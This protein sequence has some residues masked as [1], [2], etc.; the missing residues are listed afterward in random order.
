MT[1]CYSSEASGMGDQFYDDLMT[2][3]QVESVRNKTPHHFGTRKEQAAAARYMGRLAYAAITGVVKK[4]AEAM[5]YL[6]ALAGAMAHEGEPVRWVTPAG[7]PCVNRYHEA[8]QKKLHLWLHNE[9]IQVRVANGDEPELLKKK[10]QQ[11]I[12][13]NF[14]HSLDAAHLLLTVGACADEGIEV[15]TV[16]DSFGCLPV[17]ADR[18][19]QILREQFVLM[20]Q[21]Y[22][23]LT[24]SGS[25]ARAH[26]S[27]ANHWRLPPLP[28]KGTLDLNEVLNAKYA[29]A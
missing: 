10:C 24:S 14:V 20:Y 26:L 6:K 5:D 29:F 9:R 3:L 1:F 19:N 11:S 12:S 15:A 13:P 22:D 8:T 2:P 23:V 28:E 21:E 25:T 27:E 18:M 7:I 4:P 16:H 17:H